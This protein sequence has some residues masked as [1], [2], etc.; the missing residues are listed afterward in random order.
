MNTLWI[1]GCSYSAEYTHRGV[2][3][4]S[5]QRYK[6]YRN[7]LLPD[8]WGKLL[9]DKLKYNYNN[10]ADGG[11]GNEYIFEQICKNSKNFKKDDIIIIEWS[12]VDRFRWILNDEW[13]HVTANAT[14]PFLNQ[15]FSDEMLLMRT[16]DLFIKTI[17]EYENII[18]TLSDAVGFNVFF[19]LGD[20]KIA[21]LLP[22][23]KKLNKKYIGSKY[24]EDNGTI[25]NE[26]LDRRDGKIIFQETN[27]EVEDNHFGERAHKIMAELFYEHIKENI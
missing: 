23:E 20:Y 8:V 7:G 3:T 18:E 15:N 4:N 26:I 16:H 19:W 22:K 5:F 6:D 24:L 21:R 13:V 9:S 27:G 10:C 11:V 14:I 12:Y 1:F 17:F 25:F 2:I